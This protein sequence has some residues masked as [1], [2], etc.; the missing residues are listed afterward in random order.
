MNE[1]IQKF[2]DSIEVG[3]TKKVVKHVLKNV[4]DNIENYNMFDV[5]N[6]ILSMNPNSQKQ[7]VT[8]VY[9]LSL[10][11]KWL[12]EQEIVKD[13][14]LYHM[15]QGLDKKALWVK[16]KPKAK[17]KFISYEEYKRIIHDIE[18]Y[19]EYNSLYYTSLFSSIYYGMYNDDLSVLKN[20]RSSEISDGIVTLKEDTGHI[21][22]LK[23]PEKLSDDLRKLSG[24]SVWERR[25]RFNTCKVD[26]RGVYSDSVFRIEDRNTANSDASFKFSYY[27]RLRKIAKDYVEHTITPLQL[28]VSGMM[29]R[30]KDELE[31][32]GITLEQ[33]F[34]ENSRNR[35]AYQ[36]IQKELIRCNSGIELS[37]FRELV[38]GHLDSF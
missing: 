19:E 1:N 28:Y 26:M 22:K 21:Y 16:A 27:A 33:A 6:L 17:K 32:N 4:N 24:I 31:S 13:D 29:Y 35:L 36:I 3:N 37:N 15:I 11:A 12:Q 7:I 25:N 2:I 18:M 9:V 34:A 10:Y 14:S 8:V 23:I 38:K 20:L 30:I 5:E